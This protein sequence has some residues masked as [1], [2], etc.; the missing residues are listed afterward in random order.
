LKNIPQ[1][2]HASISGTVHAL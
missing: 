1:S 2:D